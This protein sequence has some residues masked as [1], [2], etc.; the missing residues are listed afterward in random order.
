MTMEIPLLIKECLPCSHWCIREGGVLFCQW[1][2][3]DCIKIDSCPVRSVECV[4]AQRNTALCLLLYNL[5]K[6][7]L[8]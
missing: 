7:S 2:G 4:K 5:K 6:D 8:C 1:Y 3:Y